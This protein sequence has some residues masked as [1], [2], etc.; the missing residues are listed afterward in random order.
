[1]AGGGWS[2]V[3]IA[4]LV[5]RYDEERLDVVVAQE[6]VAL[7]AVTRLHAVVAAEVAQRV[8]GDVNSP[9]ERA[10]TRRQIRRSSKFIH[11]SSLATVASLRRHCA[12]F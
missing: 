1:M 11:T 7:A 4:V 5:A 10:T 8:L 9:I 12:A 3:Y 6:A 2:A